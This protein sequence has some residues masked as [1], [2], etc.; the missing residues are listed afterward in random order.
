MLIRMEEKFA[1]DYTF[2]NGATR[3]C[4]ENA[5]IFTSTGSVA[6][7]EAVFTLLKKLKAQEAG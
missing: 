6:F 4:V 7:K 3:T 1:W 5:H 2:I